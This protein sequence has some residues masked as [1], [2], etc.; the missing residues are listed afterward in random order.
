MT[1]ADSFRAEAATNAPVNFLAIL[2]CARALLTRD[3]F[4][5]QWKSE[6]FQTL[7]NCC[8]WNMPVPNLSAKWMEFVVGCVAVSGHRRR[9][10]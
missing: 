1:S 4:S 5:L 6:I 9:D 8:R 3:A 10:F 2:K 7:P